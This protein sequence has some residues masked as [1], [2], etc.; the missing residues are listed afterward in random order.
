MSSRFGSDPCRAKSTRA[1]VKSSRHASQS[2]R[3]GMRPYRAELAR[4]DVEPSPPW[5]MSSRVH[6]AL[7]ETV[8]PHTTI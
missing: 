4:A 3:L 2:I 6:S 7:M 8:Q 1:H 5:P